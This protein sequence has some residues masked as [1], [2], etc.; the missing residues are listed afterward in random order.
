MRQ[1][2]S[3]VSL[4]HCPAVVQTTLKSVKLC[5][6]WCEPDY[7]CA[8]WH[9]LVYFVLPKC[10]LLKIICPCS[11][12]IFR[13]CCIIVLAFHQFLQP[14]LCLHWTGSLMFVTGWLVPNSHKHW[15]CCIAVKAIVHIYGLHETEHSG[16]CVLTLWRCVE[17]CV[18]HYVEHCVGHCWALLD[19]MLSIVL[20]TVEHCGGHYVEHCVGHCWTLCWALC[21]TL[22]ST[23]LDTVEHAHL[24]LFILSILKIQSRHGHSA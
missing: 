9:D 1:H 23:V 7:F 4:S 13:L 21:W 24:K 6:S 10:V 12:C 2:V 16:H 19:T 14:N 17:H 3:W 11:L 20:D 15:N 22:L 5:L 8:L 18:G